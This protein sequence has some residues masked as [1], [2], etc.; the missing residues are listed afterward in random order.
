VRATRKADA[1]SQGVAAVTVL[2]VEVSISPQFLTLRPGGTQCFV[3][4]VKGLSDTSVSWAVQEPGGGSL[5]PL[6]TGELGVFPA[7]WSVSVSFPWDPSQVLPA[8]HAPAQGQERRAGLSRSQ[9]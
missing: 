2:P 7:G 3:A 9:G 5:A 6:P 4:D 8:H 1:S